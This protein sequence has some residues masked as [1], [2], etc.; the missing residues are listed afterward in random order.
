[1]IIAESQNVYAEREKVVWNMVGLWWSVAV[2]QCD[3]MTGIIP[4][5]TRVFNHPSGT[6]LG[7]KN[8]YLFEV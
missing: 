8:N 5:V 2:L 7:I 1:M 6:Y 4:T 3:N